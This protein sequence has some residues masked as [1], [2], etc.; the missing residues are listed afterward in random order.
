MEETRLDSVIRETL[1]QRAS[2]VS[3]SSDLQRQIK[4]SIRSK[5]EE[6][7][8][9]RRF[10]KRKVVILA[11]AMC[12]VGSMAVAA[13]GKITSW[14]SSSNAN[15]PDFRSYSEVSKAEERLGCPVKA[16]KSFSNGYQFERGFLQ[17][18]KGADETGTIV[19]VVPQVSVDYTKGDTSAFLHIENVANREGNQSSSGMTAID[20]DGVELRYKSED[21]KFVSADYQLTAKDQAAVDAGELTVSYGTDQVE[22]KEVRYITWE[23][24]GASYQLMSFGE[25]GQ[26]ELVQMAKEL[27]AA[28]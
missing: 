1:E 19:Q 24:E 14:S 15:Q 17:D 16:V 23:Q 28:K 22:A 10:S 11:V 6:E 5:S 21:Y 2:G 27:I 13:A 8:M 9:V 26:D 20:A 4:Q 3:M 12:L 25:L 7:S 18:V